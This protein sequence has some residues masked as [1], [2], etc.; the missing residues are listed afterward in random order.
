[1]GSMS[2]SFGNRVLIIVQNLPVPFD[3]RVW[4]E[5]TTLASSGYTVSVICPK[6]KGLNKTHETLEGVNIYRYPMPFDPSSRLGFAAE[7][8]WAWLAT[9]FMSIVVGLRHGFDLIHACNPPETYWLL[10]LLWRPFGKVFVFDHHDLSPEMFQAKFGN[11]N[12]L[13]FRILRL[14]ERATFAV[15]QVSLATN[16]SHRQTAIERGKMR[17]EDVFVVRSGPDLSRLKRYE[18]DPAWGMGKDHLIVYLGDISPQDGVDG[19][20]RVARELEKIRDDFHVAVV[21]GGSAWED[22]RSYADEQGVS[23]L[24]TFTGVVSDDDLCR[25]LSSATVGVDPAPKNPWTDRSTMNKIVEYMFFGLPIVAYDLKETRYSAREAV[26]TV[27]SSDEA[28]FA[29]AISDLLEEPEARDAM[30]RIGRLRVEEELSWEHSVPHLLS[31][32]RRALNGS[33]TL[34]AATSG[35]RDPE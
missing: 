34:R 24:F 2:V 26:R 18:R 23:H 21:G 31:A 7:F 22:V 14:F 20:V 10:A 27:E 1:M 12:R 33:G 9:A 30:S 15:A 3:R 28:A 25:I 17:P 11:G 6:L 35:A 4:L 5:A 8:V 19:L 29:R 16:E 13:L 32:Y